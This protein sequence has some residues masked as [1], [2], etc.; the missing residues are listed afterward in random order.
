M[1]S[2]CLKSFYDYQAEKSGFL[3][4]FSYYIRNRKLTRPTSKAV[5]EEVSKVCCINKSFFFFLS[6]RKLLNT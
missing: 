4:K 5:A 3:L 6:Q 2:N 1:Y